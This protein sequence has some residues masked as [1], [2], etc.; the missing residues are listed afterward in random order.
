[1][2]EDSTPESAPRPGELLRSTL[3]ASEGP[4]STGHAADTSPQRSVKRKGGGQPGNTNALRHGFYSRSFTRAENTRLD[5][6]IKG[7]FHDEINLA[8]VNAN[9]LADILK[10]YKSMSIDEIIS[11]SRALN[12]YLERIQSL[13]RA[14]RDVYSN[15]TTIEQ[16]LEELKDLPFEED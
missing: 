2:P 15:Q 13:T 11:T 4:A 6:D 8:R 16:A 7:E 5:S 14:Q 10:G 3:S 9:R 12:N 1:M